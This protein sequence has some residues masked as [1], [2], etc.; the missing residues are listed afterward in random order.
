MFK[1]K[2]VF[3]LLVLFSVL[4]SYS[5]S[6]AVPALPRPTCAIS[7]TVLDVQKTK[8]QIGGRGPQYSYY[9]VKLK[10]Y[11]STVFRQERDAAD[12]FCDDLINSEKDSI[13][14]LEDYDKSPIKTGEEINANIKFSG[15]EWFGGYFLSGIKV[16][17]K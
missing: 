4:I 10:I 3:P 2:M 5:E 14:S 11:D 17:D 13:L 1:N 9:V 16:L 15:D 7:A 8:P 12:S 6:L